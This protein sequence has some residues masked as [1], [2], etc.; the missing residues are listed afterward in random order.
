MFKPPGLGVLD[1]YKLDAYG[2]LLAGPLL[3]AFS[4]GTPNGALDIKGQQAGTLLRLHGC[5][6]WEDIG[7]KNLPAGT[8]SA[9]GP[10]RRGVPPAR[11]HVP[12]P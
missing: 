9:G 6:T 10:G 2:V 8:L 12:F 5:D 7:A 3:V 11:P 4:Q 1:P